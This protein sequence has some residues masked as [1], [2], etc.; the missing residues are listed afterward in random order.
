[1]PCVSRR[2]NGSSIDGHAEIAEDAREEARVDQV[3]DGVLDAAAVEVDRSPVADLLRIERQLGVLRIAEAEEVPR[4]ID[5]RVHRVGLAP[6]RAAAVGA[7]GVD[8][9][10]NLRERRIAAAAELRG[11]RQQHRQ[12]VGRHRHHAA[13]LAVDH[14]ES[15]C[16]STAAARCPSPSADTEPCLRRCRAPRRPPSSSRS[17]LRDESR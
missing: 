4:R 14:R 16:P 6:R 15:A 8:E 5:E 10:G 11:L 3:Q 9:L 12:I 17:P 2:V 13:L 7:R 1:M